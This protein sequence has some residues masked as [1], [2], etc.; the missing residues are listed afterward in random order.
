MPF[1]INK[2][3]FECFR[4][5][6]SFR[7]DLKP[8]LNI[9]VGPNA[10]GKTNCV[11]AIQ[12]LTTGGSFKHA[13]SSELIRE[14]SEKG[15]IELMAEGDVRIAEIRVD[16]YD[17]RKVLLINGKRRPLNEVR[18]LLPS[19]LF[20]P[21]DLLLIKGP[22]KGRRDLF[23]DLGCQLSKSYD[24]VLTDYRRAVIQRNNILKEEVV[25]E[26][27]LDA[28]T[29]S[30][31]NTG[32]ILHFYRQS[33]LRRVL[34]YI[35]QTYEVISGGE[36]LSL[37]YVSTCQDEAFKISQSDDIATPSDSVKGA[38]KHTFL[39]ELEKQRNSELRR[40]QTLV[41]PHLDDLVFLI[42]NK[43]ARSYGSQGQQ[44][45]V[46]LSIK[47]AEVKLIR[48]MMGQYPVFLLDD[49]MSELDVTR[50]S[51][52]LGLVSN[53]VQSIIT[54]TNLSYFDDSEINGANVVRM[55]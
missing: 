34:P 36:A 1:I 28:W 41:G 26:S 17:S 19:V 10:V 3:L 31:V 53:D 52:L 22:A 6:S 14:G 27:L 33:L 23:D 15:S 24:R 45:S 29:H 25:D 5:F 49:V 48:E 46:V 16:L 20:C 4:N 51:H 40:R 7:L 2:V 43:S 35:T 50:R 54:T 37:D 42:D 8:G 13:P 21:D 38:F 47:M 18:G 55:Q 11:E 30:M 39:C 12:L 9:L 44:R 32:T